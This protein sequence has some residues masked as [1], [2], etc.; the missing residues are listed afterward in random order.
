[1]E[2]P[3]ED[4]DRK[5]ARAFKRW[6]NL[7]N[8]LPATAFYGQRPS[9]WWTRRHDIDLIIGTHKYG[10]ANYTQMRIDKTLSFHLL[11]NVEGSYQEFPN[12]DNI[13]RRLKKLVQMIGK[14]A[15]SGFKFD[16]MENL[17][18]PSGYNLLEK[19]TI[20]NVLLNIGVPISND[21]KYDWSQLREKVIESHAF[22]DSIKEHNIQQLERFVQRVRMICQQIVHEEK[23]GQSMYNKMPATIE[24]DTT[25]AK[26]KRIKTDENKEA[27]KVEEDEDFDDDD[28]D[29]KRNS[30]FDD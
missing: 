27:Y 24:E 11:E 15:E 21:S 19:K 12:A 10:Y 22:K 2:R 1:M 3:K 9:A 23:K 13:T 30:Y 5:I 7:L 20:I 14:Q 25:G 28:L 8:N 16:S 6:D 26:Y 4:K 17:I 18:E 29:D